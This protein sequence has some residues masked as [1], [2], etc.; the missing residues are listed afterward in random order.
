MQSSDVRFKCPECN[1]EYLGTVN[2]FTVTKMQ[3]LNTADSEVWNDEVI[4][5][6]ERLSGPIYQCEKCS[7]TLPCTTWEE[8]TEYL[9]QHKMT[10]STLY[11]NY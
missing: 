6:K 11:Q 3:I 5:K 7:Y 8:L 1:H 9:T 4:S 2:T 10:R